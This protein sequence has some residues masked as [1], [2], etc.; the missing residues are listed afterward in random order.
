VDDG[1]TTTAYTFDAFGRLTDYNS[2]EATYVY[3]G[4]D[5]VS[6]RAGVGFGYSGAGIDP[7]W[8]GTFTY[9]HSPGG[10]L[11]SVSDGTDA[12]LAGA[13]RHG[14]LTH[15]FTTTGVLAD[16]SLFDPFGEVIATS[17]SVGPT[18]GF[19]SDYTDPVS[20]HVWMGARWYDAATATFLSRDSVFGEL[21]T[22]VSLNRYTYA[23]A[24]PL[25]YW[26]PDGRA[27]ID[28][29]TIEGGLHEP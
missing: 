18:V 9:S 22:P 25:R 7:V 26:D 10:R 23:G 15:L 12:W 29:V 17:G 28:T 1:T 6:S 14:D 11:L 27:F 19:Q 20:A 21:S 13:N 3:D 16:S 8:D 4:L 24:N 5:R 2:G